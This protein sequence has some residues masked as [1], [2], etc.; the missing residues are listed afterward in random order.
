MDPCILF[1]LD[2][3]SF[4]LLLSYYSNG[5]QQ[6]LSEDR[7]FHWYFIKQILI[8]PDRVSYRKKTQ[9]IWRKIHGQV[10]YWLSYNSLQTKF[11]PFVVE[12]KASQNFMRK[13][14]DKVGNKTGYKRKDK[15]KKKRARKKNRNKIAKQLLN[16]IQ[17]EENYICPKCWKLFLAIPCL[18]EKRFKKEDLVQNSVFF[19]KN[20]L[21][22]KG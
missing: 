3:L 6:N 5:N 20:W 21:K 18:A 4:P 17:L 7:S 16:Y 10:C 1:F 9:Y 22:A 15:R 12:K 13:R 14:D 19:P 11:V 8:N 2:P